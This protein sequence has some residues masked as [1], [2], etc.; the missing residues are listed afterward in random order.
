MLTFRD[1]CRSMLAASIT[2]DIAALRIVVASLVLCLS[3]S[4]HAQTP[5]PQG[6]GQVAVVISLEGLRIPDVQVELRDLTANVIVARTRAGAIGQVTFPD[7][8]AGRYLVIATREGFADSESA[9]FDVRAGTTE[10]VPIQTASTFVRESGEVILPANSPT[11]SL[12]PVAVSDLLTGAKMDIQPLAGDD[13]QALLTLLPTIVRGPDGRLRVKGGAPTT[14]ALQVSSASLN[15]PSTGDFDLEL[16]SG[17]VESVEV[18]SN[19]FAAE[20]GRFSTS[21]TQVR[22]RRGTDEWIF[23]PGNLMPNFGRGFIDRFEPRI[24]WSGPIK[25]DRLLFGQYFQFRY[26]RTPVKSLP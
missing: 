26:A 6:P 11:E 14:G 15:D 17:A 20:Y 12:Q 21:V 10:H 8:P 9:P 18:L 4:A 23:K 22:T 5:A 7:V 25:R 1:T 3:A 13:F 2:L 16:P 24:A 19:P